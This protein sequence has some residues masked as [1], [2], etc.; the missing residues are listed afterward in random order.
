MSIF[1]IPRDKVSHARA[2]LG[3]NATY[4]LA[5]A[6]YTWTPIV[7]TTF[8]NPTNNIIQG[9]I[10]SAVIYVDRYGDI[11]VNAQINWNQVNAGYRGFRLWNLTTSTVMSGSNIG[12]GAGGQIVSYCLSSHIFAQQTFR[13]EVYQDSDVTGLVVANDATL[14]RTRIGIVWV[15][16]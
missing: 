10:N 11:T 7:W 9:A 2:V 15:E 16:Q 6:R 5:P 1:T 13:C 4:N 8:S 12:L 3:P 14:G